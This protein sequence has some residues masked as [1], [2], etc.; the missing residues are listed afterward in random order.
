M[1]QSLIQTSE[2]HM[3]R[4]LRE[5][6]EGL[7]EEIGEIQKRLGVYR[8]RLRYLH[9]LFNDLCVELLAER[10]QPGRLERE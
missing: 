5:E 8:E 10:E 3:I 4:S 9:D 2:L 1:K 6:S 7:R